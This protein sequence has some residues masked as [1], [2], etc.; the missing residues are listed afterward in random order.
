MAIF[1]PS[2]L[3]R[4]LW[5]KALGHS[6]IFLLFIIGLFSIFF[7]MFFQSTSFSLPVYVV[8]FDGQLVGKEFMNFIQGTMY[9][10]EPD[11]IIYS[12]INYNQNPDNVVKAVSDGK[13]WGAI[14]VMPR[15]SGPLLEAAT[16]GRVNSY[17]PSK[18][19]TL[20]YDSG[21]DPSVASSVLIPM[22]HVMKDFRSDFASQWVGNLSR[23][24]NASQLMTSLASNT[25]Q[26]L[27]QVLDWS[28]NDIGSGIVPLVEPLLTIGMMILFLFEMGAVQVIKPLLLNL[29]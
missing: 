27:T 22:R 17:N 28:E 14:M 1:G 25:P 16:I 9:S 18:M 11:W 2:H 24:A 13:A 12:P 10:S 20:V 21:R 29:N 8:D 15:A 3:E 4:R 5:K 19:F 7:G 26:I 6:G 23:S